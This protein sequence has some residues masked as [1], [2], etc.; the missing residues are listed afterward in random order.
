MQLQHIPGRSLTIIVRILE[1]HE[2][3]WHVLA[4]PPD[5]MNTMSIISAPA[6]REDLYHLTIKK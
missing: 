2:A 3:I 1:S 4:R 5:D 6:D